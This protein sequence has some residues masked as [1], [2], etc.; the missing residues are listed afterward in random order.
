MLPTRTRVNG[1]LQAVPRKA[2]PS[3]WL[4]V[5]RWRD[6][7]PDQ[8]VLLCVYRT[9]HVPDVQRIVDEVLRI[10]GEVRLWALEEEAPL[11][12]AQTLGAGPGQ[13]TELLNRLWEARPC[14][15]DAAVVLWDDDAVFE[16]GDL[17]R[18]LRVVQRGGFD[19]AQPTHGPGAHR[20][21]KVTF[22]RYLSIARWVGW[23]EVGPVVVVAPR[24]RDEVLPL[25]SGF[26]MGWGIELVWH[27]QARAGGW[28]LGMVDA[29]S[30]HHLTVV[31]TDYDVEPERAR[32]RPDA[33]R[34]LPPRDPAPAAPGHLAAL[35]APRAVARPV[36]GQSVA[37]SGGWLPSGGPGQRMRPGWRVR[38]ATQPLHRDAV[39]LDDRAAGRVV[40]V[41]RRCRP[42]RRSARRRPG[43]P[44]RR[45]ARR[46]AC[47]AAQNS[48]MRASISSRAAMR[49]LKVCRSARSPKPISS[50]TRAATDSADVETATHRPSEHCHVPRGTEYGMPEPRRGCR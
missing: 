43:P 1:V 26:G 48:A 22:S 24:V 46:P 34:A 8:V 37:H 7:L 47:R 42:C 41:G 15:P 45:A 40:R 23:I 21:W 44:R 35:A 17:A 16:R 36:T 33:Q 32:A 39:D 12:A 25:P 20:G 6:P 29:V 10:G 27:D 31:G 18:L 13:R 4:R 49:P 19:M 30:I 14:Q 3:Y 5:R 2:D 9:R 11:L 38:R 50:I 28:R